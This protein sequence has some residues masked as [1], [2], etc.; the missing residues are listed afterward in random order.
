MKSIVYSANTNTQTVNAG[1]VVNFGSP[2]RRY[3]KKVNV[4]GGNLSVACGYYNIDTNFTFTATGD[5]TIQLYKDGNPISGAVA[6]LTGVADTV[7][8]ITIPCVVRQMCCCETTI[9]AQVGGVPATFSNAS[10]VAE[11]V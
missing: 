8:N 4:T 3:G 11:E 1:G 2:V 6:T 5:I 10:I 9:T 7:Y